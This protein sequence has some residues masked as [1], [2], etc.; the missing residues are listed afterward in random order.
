MVSVSI[1]TVDDMGIWGYPMDRVLQCYRFRDIVA[2]TVACFVS[3]HQITKIRYFVLFTL[4]L[5]VV[6][7]YLG[8]LSTSLILGCDIYRL[9]NISAT[10]APGISI[11]RR[12]V[13]T[14]DI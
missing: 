1:G 3:S 9:T 8:C 11:I 2:Q 6:Y 5:Q 7:K 13:H 14:A 10:R 4:G 12:C